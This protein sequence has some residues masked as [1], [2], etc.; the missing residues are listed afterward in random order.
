VNFATA[1]ASTRGKPT[2]WWRKAF[3]IL[4]ALAITGGSALAHKP[5]KDARLPTIGPA[6]EFTLTDQEG[7]PFS[8]RDVRGK[9]AVVTFI[10]TTCSDTCP[11][12]TAKLV[13]IQK[14]LGPDQSKVF[15]TAVTVDPLNDT[16]P[17][18]K[19]YAQAHSADLSRFAFLTGSMGEIEDVTR[20]YA[21]FQKKQPSGSVDHTFLTSIVDQAGIL[22]V[23]YLGVRFDP[24]EFLGD[25]KSV[26]AEAPRR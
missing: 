11:L 18:L 7:K 1:I 19:K 4:A 9:V 10:F 8:L 25:L 14:R 13:G 6:P 24:K 21:I 20:R 2:P 22:R 12:L 16:P 5:G 26:L 15:F 17:V 23:Q 3:F